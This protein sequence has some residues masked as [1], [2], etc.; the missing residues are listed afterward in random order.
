MRAIRLVLSANSGCARIVSR[1]KLKGLLAFTA[2]RKHTT[3]N[4]ATK[5]SQPSRSPLPV[6]TDTKADQF[7]G[8]RFQTLVWTRDQGPAARAIEEE[9]RDIDPIPVPPPP[10]SPDPAVE[11]NRLEAKFNTP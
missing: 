2:Q 7:R 4:Q 8:G 5:M 3:P 10:V 9:V 6:E 11:K 1:S